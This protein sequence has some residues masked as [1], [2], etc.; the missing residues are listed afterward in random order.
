MTLKYKREMLK[1]RVSCFDDF[2][3]SLELVKKWQ[4]NEELKG[5]DLDDIVDNFLMNYIDKNGNSE[6]EINELIRDINEV[7]YD[8]R[9]MD[10][11][12]MWQ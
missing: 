6:E 2:D 7:E 9:E 12:E 5:I 8:D 3:N 10:V 11:E 4:G 1:E